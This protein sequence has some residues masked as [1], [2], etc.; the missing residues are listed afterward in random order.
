MLNSL[1]ENKRVAAYKTLGQKGRTQHEEKRVIVGY[2]YKSN[3]PTKK[4]KRK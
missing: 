2:N 4:G 1:E 3:N